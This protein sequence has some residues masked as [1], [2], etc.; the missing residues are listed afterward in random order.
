MPREGGWRT[1]K[2][3]GAM[4]RRRAGGWGQGGGGEG[5]GGARRR[6][7]VHDV[8]GSGRSL[9]VEPLEA[10][11]ANNRLLEVRAAAGEEERRILTELAR[12]VTDAGEGL[13]DLEATLAH[14][15]GLRARARWAREFGGTAVT[16][17]GERLRLRRAR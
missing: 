9:F 7:V 16:P 2:K 12:A 5:A 3:V 13:R 8:S 4:R 1:V 17:G 6:A 11:E 10:C 14:L 15:D